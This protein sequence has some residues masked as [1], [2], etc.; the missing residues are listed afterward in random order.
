MKHTQKKTI[1]FIF[2]P[3]IATL[4][5]WL[6]IMYRVK[7]QKKNIRIIGVFPNQ[8][9]ASLINDKNILLEISNNIFE[10][11][12]IQRFSKKWFKV[13]DLK[14][15]RKFSN[16][17]Y[18][19]HK[20]L[21]IYKVL[22]GRNY[23]FLSKIVWF[24]FRLYDKFK[25]LPYSKYLYNINSVDNN[26]A[27]VFYDICKHYSNDSYDLN[28]ALG[29]IKRFSIFHG[30]VIQERPIQSNESQ[31]YINTTAYLFSDKEKDF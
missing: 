25:S 2:K 1:Y 26:N 24:I 18:I 15:A 5:G 12:L 28:N 8:T 10:Y 3:S 31:K 7:E 13:A 4:D 21:F 14:S 27:V 9:I 11:V 17:S 20:I 16:I 19:E 23:I 30:P 29:N 6:P 22:K